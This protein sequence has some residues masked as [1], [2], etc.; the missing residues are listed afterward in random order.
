MR[1]IIILLP[2]SVLSAHRN[3]LRKTRGE[4]RL[5]RPLGFTWVNVDEDAAGSTTSSTT[6]GT[7]IATLPT[8]SSTEGFDA[9][10]SPIDV[11]TLP[12]TSTTDSMTSTSSAT[13][14][15]NST[16]FTEFAS[17]PSSIDYKWTAS[18][19]SDADCYPKLRVE[20]PGDSDPIGV[21]ICG[22]YANTIAMPFDE[23]QGDEACAIAGCFRNSCDGF[24]AYCSE[25]GVCRLQPPAL[26]VTTTLPADA[27]VSDL[28]PTWCNDDSNCSNNMI[29][30]DKSNGMCFAPPC[31]RCVNPTDDANEISMLSPMSMSLSMSMQDLPVENEFDF[32]NEE[33]VSCSN[34]D[35]CVQSNGCCLSDGTC[36]PKTDA[37]PI[38]WSLA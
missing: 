26:G 35:D 22:C 30:E 9:T 33:I 32:V 7:D 13:D 24:T 31:G 28:V 20:I 12:A 17:K 11:A 19:I 16:P 4:T 10:G 25:E 29:C 34:H 23:C 2:P 14:N 1:L 27:S 36:H 15:I 6:F 5:G 18:C 21:G 38:C 8:T 37:M 3:Y